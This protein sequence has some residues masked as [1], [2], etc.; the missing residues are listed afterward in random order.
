MTKQISFEGV[1][2]AAM[3]N[4]SGAVPVEVR[5]LGPVTLGTAQPQRFPGQP[6]PS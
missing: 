6:E 5:P 2:I 3:G 1:T 4:H